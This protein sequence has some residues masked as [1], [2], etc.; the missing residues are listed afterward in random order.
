[1][2]SR[3]RFFCLRPLRPVGLRQFA[4]ADHRPCRLRR[5]LRHD[6]KARRP[7]LIDKPVIVGGGRGVVATC[8]YVARAFGVRSAM[9]MFEAQGPL[10]ECDRDQAGHEQ[11]RPRSAARAHADVRAHAAGRAA[12]DRRS[13]PRPHRTEGCT[14]SAPALACFAATSRAR[15]R[16]TVSVGLRPTS[17]WRRSPPISTS[18]AACFDF[19]GGSE[20]PARPQ[21]SAHLGRG[22]GRAGAA[23]RGGP[24]IGDLERGERTV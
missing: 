21:G 10:P 20:G 11:I 18:R 5:L 9:P 17:F 3:Q 12:V 22:R 19:A 2:T 4:G 8:C 16:I 24:V 1:M 6:R 7:E 15:I 14:A 23:R 13:L